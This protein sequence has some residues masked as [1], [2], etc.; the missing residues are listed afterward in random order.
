MTPGPC[1]STQHSKSFVAIEKYYGF[2]MDSGI[3]IHKGFKHAI[4]PPLR[5]LEVLGRLVQGQRLLILI[6]YF[7][8]C[9]PYLSFCVLYFSICIPYCFPN[10]FSRI[11][12]HS[13]N[14]G[15][16]I[17]SI[18]SPHL[19]HIVFV[20]FKRNMENQLFGAL[21]SASARW[22]ECPCKVP[23]SKRSS[24]RGILKSYRIHIS[25]FPASHILFPYSNHKKSSYLDCSREVG[26]PRIW[27]AD[28]GSLDFKFALSHP[29]N[30]TSSQPPSLLYHHA[31]T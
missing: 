9:I 17:P 5:H 30:C 18:F 10:I 2:N 8:I 21:H 25:R 7:S 19:F 15:V 20:F 29:M 16:H 31:Q 3:W 27:I 28:A 22:P 14:H 6:P 4:Y 24:T 23:D 26:V 1:Y 12:P 11:F 13:G